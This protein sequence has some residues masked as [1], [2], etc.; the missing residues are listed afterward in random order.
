M[1]RIG[2]Q[3]KERRRNSEKKNKREYQW[4]KQPHK[5]K[6]EIEEQNMNKIDQNML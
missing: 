5:K 1:G 6:W 2:G 4:I 3:Q